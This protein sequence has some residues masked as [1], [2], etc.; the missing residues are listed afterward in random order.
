MI[1]DL[2]IKGSTFC[3]TPPVCSL[4]CIIMA[5]THITVADSVSTSVDPFRIGPIQERPEAEQT[6][7]FILTFKKELRRAGGVSQYLQNSLVS[8]EAQT[9]F[10]EGLL[11]LLPKDPT[12]DY[13]ETFPICGAGP[14][15]ESS[16]AHVVLHL[17]KFRFDSCA[18]LQMDPELHDS[19]KLID[20]YHHEGFIT[21]DNMI[22]IKHPA[23]TGNAE[24]LLPFKVGYVKGQ[25]RLL[26]L[27]ALAHYMIRHGVL[28]GEPLL[29]TASKIMCKHVIFQDEKSELFY[30]MSSS[31]R[32][33]LRKATTVPMWVA[34]LMKCGD[35]S[36]GLVKA[37]N[38]TCPKSDRIVG[39]KATSIKNM[40]TL[41]NR[42]R[43]AIFHLCSLWG[44]AGTP[45]TDDN[46]GHK[47]LAVGASFKTQRTP[48]NSPWATWGRVTE[49]SL[50]LFVKHIQGLLEQVGNAGK[51][52]NADFEAK[53]EMCTLAWWLMQETE[54]LGAL[55]AGV[56]ENKFYKRVADADPILE[57]ELMSCLMQKDS[58]YKV[59][60][61]PTIASILNEN[62]N[63]RTTS[64]PSLDE[65][66]SDKLNIEKA[67]FDLVQ[68]QVAYDQKTYEVWRRKMMN[69]TTAMSHNKDVWLQNVILNNKKVVDEFLRNKVRFEVFSPNAHDA[70]SEAVQQYKQIKASI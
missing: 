23:R 44:F 8:P 45:F 40:L 14:G 65:I 48:S 19:E 25:G 18:S 15:Q 17:S 29:S 5:G 61:C 63:Q 67:D 50:M 58:N 69:Y 42:V 53:L 30:S 46:L 6:E 12:I 64:M 70:A 9:Q 52:S 21:D 62:M 26:P 60:D 16:L 34:S 27:L 41:P 35:E 56:L 66:T 33:Q 38:E 22:R 2:C 7:S 54:R 51:L 13:V 1:V 47:K 32:G 11:R 43:D 10:A 39:G 28:M 59:R 31:N 68:K 24:P 36:S 37:W 3:H 55:P 4:A 57:V 20:R 49:E